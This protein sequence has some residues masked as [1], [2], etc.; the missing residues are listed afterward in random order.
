MPPKS[1]CAPQ[2][3]ADEIEH[4]D[5]KAA[6]DV[7]ALR[8]IGDIADVEPVVIDRAGQRLSG[9]RRCRET[10]STCRRRSD[11]Q[12]QQRAR[13]N[14]AVEVM[15][16]RMAVIAQRDVAKSELGVIVTS[17]PAKR[18]PRAGADATAAQAALATVMRR[19]DHGAACAGWGVAGSWLC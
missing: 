15:H 7:D 4:R 6:I 18:C 3:G 2:P 1:R 9:C 11:R 10:A 5:R 14:I 8:Q 12:R 13:G 19:I 16:R 17:S